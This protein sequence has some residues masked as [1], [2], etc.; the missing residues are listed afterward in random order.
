M[1]KRG[2]TLIELMIVVVIIGILAA[3]AIP[4][5]GAVRD[6]AQQAACR[7]NMRSLASAESMYF[8]K[9]NTYASTAGV[10]A[11][12]HVMDNAASVRCPIGNAAYAYAGG[13]T[14]SIRCGSESVWPAAFPHGSVIDGIMSWQGE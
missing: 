2:F 9:Y 13:A 7:S 14:Y 4:K 3:I 12:T 1:K 8:G 10:L 5:F 6:Q 11:S